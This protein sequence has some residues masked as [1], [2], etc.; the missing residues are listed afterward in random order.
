MIE[1]W[2]KAILI[3][4]GGLQGCGGCKTSPGFRF[5]HYGEPSFPPNFSPYM[6]VLVSP[7]LLEM[8]YYSPKMSLKFEQQNELFLMG[9]LKTFLF[10]VH[11]FTR[12]C[13]Q[14]LQKPAAGRKPLDLGRR[15]RKGRSNTNDPT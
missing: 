12:I 8:G 4:A 9:T 2:K 1:F 13:N 7:L 5:F 14:L 11:I 6:K 15:F 3:A 10:V